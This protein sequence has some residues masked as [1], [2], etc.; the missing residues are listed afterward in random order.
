[1]K[2]VLP[3]FLLI[4]ALFGAAVAAGAIVFWLNGGMAQR[5]QTVLTYEIAPQSTYGKSPAEMRRLIT[6][7]EKRIRLVWSNQINVQPVGDGRIEICIP[8]S[9]DKLVE[10][11][12]LRLLHV[13]MLEF[14]LLA[15]KK[16]DEHASLIQWS[17]AC[18]ME[19]VVCDDTGDMLGQWV[20]FAGQPEF[21]NDGTITRTVEQNGNMVT[22]ILAVDDDYDLGTADIARV[23]IKTNPRGNIC[24][25]FTFTG[26]GEE[27][28]HL[29]LDD[30][31]QN[32]FAMESPLA[33]TLITLVD[34]KVVSMFQNDE[35]IRFRSQIV[36]DGFFGI[37]AGEAEALVVIFRAGPLPTAIQEAK[38]QVTRFIEWK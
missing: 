29:L 31:W 37:D 21:K 23:T 13:G 14:R 27:R 2:N 28:L 4:T 16:C 24:L 30:T 22:E 12:R 1:M 11:V 38:P 20:P 10:Q 19:R 32:M 8:G 26:N 36:I 15:T 25:H 18:G 3:I 7:M 5:R 35:T 6:A 33:P 17:K 34:G 9:N